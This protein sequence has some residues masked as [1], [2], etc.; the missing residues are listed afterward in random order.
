MLAMGID[1]TSARFLM[2]CAQCGVDFSQS[3]MLGR[4]E[5]HGDAQKFSIA[6]R[7]CGFKLDDEVILAF[8]DQKPAYAEPFL[9]ALGATSIDSMDAASYEDATIIHDLNVP[10]PAELK[11]RFSMVFD[12]GTIEHVFNFPIAMKNSMELVRVGGHLIQIT[13]ANNH[14]GHGFYQ[15]SPEVFY[16]VLSPENGFVVEGVYLYE[17][18]GLGDLTGV[19]YSAVDPARLKRRVQLRNV[20]ETLIVVRSRRVSDCPILEKTPQQSD[21]AA[22]WN[23]QDQPTFAKRKISQSA[24]KALRMKLREIFWPIKQAERALRY[25]AKEV[26]YDREAYRK[27][28]FDRSLLEEMRGASRVS[29]QMLA[30]Q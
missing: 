28:R 27:V 17:S 4:Q 22:L 30:G 1:V 20:D 14:M 25:G 21:Y 10:L 15:F 12:G 8:L 9:A 26:R 18:S 24:S 7:E 16:R 6:A 13:T 19:A 23:V 11:N 5:M 2:L 29:S 3:L